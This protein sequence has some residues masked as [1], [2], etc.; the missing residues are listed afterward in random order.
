LIGAQL[1][2]RVAEGL[3][4]RFPVA[5]NEIAG[6]DAD[7]F[8]IELVNRQTETVFMKGSLLPA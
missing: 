5:I 3:P 1:S 8:W 6:G 4:A 2:G 7:P